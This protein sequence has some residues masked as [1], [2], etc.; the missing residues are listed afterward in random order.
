LISA[1]VAGDVSGLALLALAVWLAR[2]GRD[3]KQARHRE[4]GTRGD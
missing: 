1:V 2:I 3:A 4:R